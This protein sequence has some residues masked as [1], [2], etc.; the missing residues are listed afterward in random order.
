MKYRSTLTIIISLTAVFLLLN[1]L[2]NAPG[3]L[4]EETF[5]DNP[6]SDVGGDDAKP[7]TMSL[8]ECVALTVRK[9]V[10]I[11]VAYLNR[12]LQKYDLVTDT[13]FR[14]VPQVGI[15]GK[16][17]KSEDINSSGTTTKDDTLSGTA[18]VTQKIPSGGNFEFSYEKSRQHDTE[19]GS[20]TEN[21][22][23]N[24]STWTVTLTQP[25]L[26]SAG[27][28]Y[29]LSN[30][31]QAEIEEQQNIVSLKGTIIDT[32]SQAITYYRALLEAKHSMEISKQSMEIAQK[33]LKNAQEEVKYGRLASMDLIQYESD[34]AN[35]ELSLE[36]ARN[37][38][39]N[40][41]L[42]LAKHLNIDKNTLIIPSEDLD[43]KEFYL[44]EKKS[45]TLAKANKPDY[46]TQRL[47]LESKEYTLLRASRDTLPQLD[48]TATYGE[49]H[50]TTNTQGNN[51]D[52]KWS[53]GL[54]LQTPIFG[55]ERRQLTSTE[56]SARS[57]VRIAMINLKKA[58]D[59]IASEVADKIRD[60][61]IKA[62]S[63]KLAVRARKLSE[64][65]LQVEQAKLKAG[66]SST[67]QVVTFQSDLF[68]ARNSELS[69][70]INYLNALTDF[71]QYLGT[72]LDTWKIDFK[73]QRKGAAESIT[74]V[75]SDR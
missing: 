20:V 24:T 9:N 67:F 74:E 26:K 56:L 32:I 21:E 51:N 37:S 66:R 41:R 25:L 68:E 27:F 65:K 19:S 54:E 64:Q 53:V 48:L 31:R 12:V 58:E 39:I 22:V 7:V 30:V 43:I 52:D 6:H 2:Y 5:A 35:R 63:A 47:N 10:T 44:D 59:D 46:L 62:K 49:T 50:T 45:N 72:T 42:D 4:A 18:T 14:Y 3:A 28:D 70:K 8:G 1:C 16:A 29:D 38:Y 69:S 33:S 13:T 60:L 36:E 34:L 40:A 75:Q 15:D 23:T 11:E 73:T 55:T 57:A 17:T 61:K 71:D